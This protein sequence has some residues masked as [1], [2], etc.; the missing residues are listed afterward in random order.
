MAEESFARYPLVAQSPHAHSWLTFL[1]NLQRSP[2][3]VDAYARDLQDYFAFCARQQVVPEAA[4][5]DDIAR[6]VGDMATRLR[7]QATPDSVRNTQVGLANATMQRRLTAVRLFYDYLVEEQ[8]CPYNPVSRG[9]YTPG[10]GFGGARDRGLLRRYVR[11][12]WIPN[13]EQ[14]SAILDAVQHEPFRNRFM[15]AL[16]YDAALRREELCCLATTDI[17]P[18]KRLVHVRAETTKNQKAR[19]VPFSAATGQLMAAYLVER[20][21]LGRSRGPLFLSVSRRNHAQPLSKWAWSKIM[22]QIALRAD[23]PALTP[24][25]LRHLC[26]TDLASAGWDLREIADFAGHSSVETTRMYIRLTGRDLAKKLAAGMDSVHGWRV[27]VMGE[28]FQ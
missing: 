9:R 8:H 11:L 19:I 4:Q 28:V 17:E 2:H 21:E 24:H 27:R 18:G 14:W 12:P 6:Y 26:L 15:F 5:R 22:R 16:S 1:A 13:A 10:R 25:T 3:T 23:M 7:P 20:R